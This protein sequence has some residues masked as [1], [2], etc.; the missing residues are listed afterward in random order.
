MTTLVEQEAADSEARAKLY[1]EQRQA[2]LAYQTKLHASLAGDPA[3]FRVLY[4]H[5]SPLFDW[6]AESEAPPVESQDELDPLG[7][8]DQVNVGR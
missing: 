1:R 5:W 8:S 7:I 6:L 3:A 2:R 4:D